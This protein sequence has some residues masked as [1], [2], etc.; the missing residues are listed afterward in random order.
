M[1]IK[2]SE[3]ARYLTEDPDIFMELDSL[4]VG[5]MDANM[6]SAEIEQQAREETPD[7]ADQQE[8]D[9]LSLQKEI[10]Q[11]EQEKKRD[12][13]QPQID[14]IDK[15]LGNIRTGFQQNLRDTGHRE[16]NIEDLGQEIADLDVALNMFSKQAGI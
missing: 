11:Q 13:L 9:E 5:P 16:Q 6:T 15:S 4:D 12:I 2:P 1:M 10:E 7:D 8:V 14:T 3:I